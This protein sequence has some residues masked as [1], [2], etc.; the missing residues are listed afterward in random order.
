M[1]GMELMILMKIQRNYRAI[2]QHLR[3]S[4][5]DKNKFYSKKLKEFNN[6]NQQH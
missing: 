2:R 1:L 6:R 5:K 4:S 3:Y